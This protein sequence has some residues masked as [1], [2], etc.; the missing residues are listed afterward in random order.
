MREHSEQS[1]M[2]LILDIFLV[3]TLILIDV[4][5]NI[6]FYDGCS[7]NDTE[8]LIDEKQCDVNLIIIHLDFCFKLRG[9]QGHD[10]LNFGN[11]LDRLE[12]LGNF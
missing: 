12:L 1:N 9:L 8:I 10:T 3:R 6:Y 5:L 2:E 11:F 7:E 4:S